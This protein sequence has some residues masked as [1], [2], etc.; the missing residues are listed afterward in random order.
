MTTRLGPHSALS[1]PHQSS[2]SRR[3]H[4]IECHP[5][6]LFGLL[7][8]Q[9]S[10]ATA[11]II[12]RIRNHIGIRIRIDSAFASSLRLRLR[13]CLCLHLHCLLVS[14]HHLHVSTVFVSSA[15]GGTLVPRTLKS[16]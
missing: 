6:A 7:V 9:C 15:V 16:R 12:T 5:V 10:I 1:C 14:L 11:A 2:E 8:I 3:A 4:S 13:L